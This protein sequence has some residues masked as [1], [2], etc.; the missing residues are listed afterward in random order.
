VAFQDVGVRGRRS[1]VAYS[2][3]APRQVPNTSSPGLNCVTFLPTASTWPATSTPGRLIFDLPSPSSN[4][5]MNGSP[6]INFQ[7]RGLTEAARTFIRT[8]LSAGV[9]LS[10]SSNL[11]ISG[12]PKFWVSLQ[13]C[14]ESILA[15][16]GHASMPSALRTILQGCRRDFPFPY[17]KALAEVVRRCLAAF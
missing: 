8:S 11:R 9:G 2:A 6:F 3:N 14:A 12:E 13:D 10:I 4:R 1:E 17:G 15:E 5:R 16:S 7:S